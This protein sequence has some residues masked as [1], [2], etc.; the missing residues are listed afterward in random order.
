MGLKSDWWQKRARTNIS[1]FYMDYEDLQVVHFGP[2]QSNPSFGSFT[3]TNIETSTISGV[4]F[5]G[6]LLINEYLDLEGNYAYLDSEVDNFQLTTGAG[7]VDLSGSSLRQAPEHSSALAVNTHFPLSDAM[8]TLHAR[9]DY[10]YKG[11]QISDYINQATRIDA[12]ELYNADLRWQSPAES[13]ALTLWIK[14][15]KDTRYI[16]HAFS[17][18][19]GV[20]GIWGAPRTVGLTLTW[21]LD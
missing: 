8:G 9:I 13:L 3:T 14:N 18:G 5:E 15:I 21:S 7:V 20:I 10:Q 17:I 19:P 1:L 12:V 4:E 16:S 2:S 11:E 6:Q